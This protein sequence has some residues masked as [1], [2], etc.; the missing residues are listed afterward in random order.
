MTEIQEKILEIFQQVSIL[1][2]KEKIE[3]YAIGGTCIGAIRD[4]GF[5]PWDDDMDIAIPIEQFNKFIDIARQQLPSKYEVL[6]YK[7]SL[8]YSEIFIKVIDK[9]T[10]YIED[11]KMNTEDV[12]LILCRYL[13]CRKGR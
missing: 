2:E 7:E 12:G 11:C 10:S 6:T 1:C 9:E 13:V 3:Y 5:V 8:H 4:K